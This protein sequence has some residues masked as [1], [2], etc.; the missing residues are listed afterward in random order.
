MVQYFNFS[1]SHMDHDCHVSLWRRRVTPILRHSVFSCDIISRH[2]RETVSALSNS[3]SIA[4]MRIKVL[5]LPLIYSHILSCFPSTISLFPALQS[6]SQLT[7]RAAQHPH[8][9]YPHHAFYLLINTSSSLHCCSLCR[10]NSNQVPFTRWF[11]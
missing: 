6:S 1:G 2:L 11:S 10:S 3:P 5:A 7:L 9:P 8:H 4:L